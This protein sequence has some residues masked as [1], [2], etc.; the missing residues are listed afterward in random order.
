MAAMAAEPT[1]SRRPAPPQ[2]ETL[3]LEPT[4]EGG[5]GAI[6]FGLIV[7]R[8][9][10]LRRAA[11]VASG[12]RRLDARLLLALT[13]NRAVFWSPVAADLPWFPDRPL[14][15]GEPVQRVFTRID[16]RLATP[17]LLLKPCLSALERA[18]GLAPPFVLLPSDTGGALDA[19]DL[20]QSLPVADIDW[21]LVASGRP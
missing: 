12:R 16:L 15:L 19:I 13:P 18:T 14:Y 4:P 3:R 11:D 10:L 21:D 9:T 7:S 1:L 2:P 8:D 20:G 17:P 5:R 6:A